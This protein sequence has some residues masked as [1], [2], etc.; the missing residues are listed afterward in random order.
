LE[1]HELLIQ[2]SKEEG[3][4]LAGVVD[5][6]LAFADPA[7]HFN[8]HLA[9][10]DAWIQA[11]YAGSMEYLVRGRDRK[12]DPRLVFPPAQSVL[13]VAIPYP[14]KKAGNSDES[15]GPQYARYLQGQDYHI[16][17]TEKL[18][19]AMKTTQLA[20]DAA[21][22]NGGQKERPS[23]EWKICVD[24]SA[25]LE[26]TWAT[27]AGLGWIGKNTLLI[28]PQHGSYLFLAEVL[29]NYKTGLG[30]AL[31]PNLCGNCTRCLSACPT[32]AL[33]KPGVLNSNRC[34][35]YLTLEKRG[36]LALDSAT[37]KKLGTWVAGCDICQEV[38]P[39]NFKP[40]R[41]ELSSD[42]VEIP[43]ATQ[44]NHWRELLLETPDQYKERVRNSAM[45]RV[46]PAQFSRNLAISLQNALAHKMSA[47]FFLP[48]LPLIQSRLERETDPAAQQE[49]SKLC[50]ILDQTDYSPNR[51]P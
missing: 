20:W 42:L 15:L 14:R 44:L 17:I 22:Q 23:L 21:S 27:L 6:D 4:P 47:T 1:L 49:W 5:I 7:D 50:S 45:K 16:E 25:V 46:K 37:Q 13:S 26:R 35:S 29:I 36:E 51:K 34:V 39:F 30:P 3:F 32:D 18:E 2:S 28:H 24:T 31:L 38:C 33:E 8:R 12:A 9:H 41:K 48:L 10:Y 19:R 43:N 40:T 11:G